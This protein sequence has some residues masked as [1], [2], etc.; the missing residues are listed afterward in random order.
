MR[1]Y[2]WVMNQVQKSGNEAY[3]YWIYIRCSRCDEILKTHVD[4]RNDLSIDYGDDGESDTY[5]TRKIIVGNTLCFEPI[6]LELKFDAK[7]RLLSQNI[8]G[9]ELLSE[10]EYYS[11]HP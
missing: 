10:E 3:L 6:E 5:F 7:R 1:L 4:L 9:G 8:T 11:Y 2:R